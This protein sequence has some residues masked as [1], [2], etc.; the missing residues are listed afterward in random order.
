MDLRRKPNPCKAMRP[1]PARLQDGYG[2]PTS[3][4]A[5]PQQ[6]N[7][8]DAVPFLCPRLR[9]R[10]SIAGTGGHLTHQSVFP[11]A[12]IVPPQLAL[13]SSFIARSRSRLGLIPAR[14]SGSAALSKETWPARE[15]ASLDSRED[16]EG[17]RSGAAGAN[18][19]NADRERG[20]R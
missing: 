12:Q 15:D 9:S 4:R 3:E 7:M 10:L 19:A 14:S 20:R 17:R 11:I 8:E 13:R 16:E 2:A 6:G 1:G 18:Y 5:T